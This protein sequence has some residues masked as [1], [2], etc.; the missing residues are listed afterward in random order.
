MTQHTTPTPTAH[1]RRSLKAPLAIGSLIV[2]ILAGCSSSSST[3]D[4]GIGIS[5]I[6]PAATGD[7]ATFQTPFDATP[8]PDG[9]NV[10]FT[11][12]TMDGTPAVFKVAASGGPVTALVT[13]DPLVSPFGIS[14]SDDGQTLFI[15]DASADAAAD[16]EDSGGIYTLPIAGGKPSVL[17]G[18]AGM[19]PR[20]VQVEG[21]FVYFTG[22]QGGKPGAFKAALA[23]GAVSQLGASDGFSDPSG[24]AVTKSGAVLVM[25]SSPDGAVGSA[26]IKID[27]AGQ[28]SVLKDGLAVGHP[29]GVALLSDDSAVLVSGLDSGGMD[30]VYKVDLASGQMKSFNDV[31][32]NFTESAGLHR[33][34]GSDKFAWADSKAGGT[35][36]VYVLAK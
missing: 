28:V 9:Q 8:D 5:H 36:T 33:A 22:F 29:A 15:A 10:Y 32:G 20:G 4:S 1:V 17:G 19:H 14:I 30:V 2:A 11:A 24:I 31:I 7:G 34:K 35:G 18:T 26:L 23:G 25:D 3:E 21:D 13:G 6:D 12:L 16:G 27:E